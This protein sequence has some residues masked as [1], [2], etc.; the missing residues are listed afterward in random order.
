MSQAFNL[1]CTMSFLSSDLAGNAQYLR[2]LTTGRESCH[3]LNR[4]GTSCVFCVFWRDLRSSSWNWG[5][6]TSADTAAVRWGNCRSSQWCQVQAKS[7]AGYF[8]DYSQQFLKL[9]THLLLCLFQWLIQK[10]N[11]FKYLSEGSDNNHVQHIESSN[12]RV[13]IITAHWFSFTW[14]CVDLLESCC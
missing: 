5:L 8:A 9:Q 13:F 11:S 10:S 7:L 1:T 4:I 14:R 12:N 6:C 2:L 3:G